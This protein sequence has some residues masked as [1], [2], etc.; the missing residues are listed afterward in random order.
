MRALFA[1]VTR[2]ADR[3]H[4]RISREQLRAAGVDR[5]RISR[6]IADG[7][8]RR[9][10]VGVYAVGHV[11]PSADGEYV[12]AVLAGGPGAVLSHRAA[13]YKLGLLRG[14]PPPPEISIPTTSHR[15]RP[16]IV[17]HRVSA[18]H[19]L[20]TAVLDHIPITIV[21]RILLDLAPAM[22]STELIRICHEAWV[23]HGTTPQQIEA[24][25]ARNPGKPAAGKLREALG[26]DVTLSFLEDAFLALLATHGLPRPRTN[27]DVKADKVDCHWPDLDLTIELLSY[28]FHATRQAFEDDVARRRRSNHL[29]YTYGDVT[30]RGAQTA[31]ELRPLL[32]D[33]ARTPTAP[34]RSP[35]PGAARCW[36]AST[37]S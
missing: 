14:A 21:P 36:Q 15:R 18:L 32:L 13:A 17:I 28:R 19:V 16:G 3:Q 34:R 37:P 31:A 25:V 29:A 1:R 30:Q 2:I 6:W 26:A 23:R 8:L 10:H 12:A 20:D 7:R 24:C 11:A 35:D 5:N 22:A 4:G 9:V 27:V 33:S